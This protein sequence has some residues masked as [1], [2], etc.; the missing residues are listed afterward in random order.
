MLITMKSTNTEFL[1]LLQK[2]P[3]SF[4]GVQLRSIKNGTGIGFIVS[5]T[6]YHMIF[7]DTKYSF[8]DQETRSQ[9][10]FQSYCNPRVFLELASEFLRH[11]Y[12]SKSDWNNQIVPWLNKSY[13]ELDVSHIHVLEIENVYVDSLAA[14][15]EF[16]FQKYFP[17]VKLE[18]KQGR[19]YNL[20]ITTDTVHR[21]INLSALTCMYLSATNDQHWYLGKELVQKYIKIMK[22][23]E[24]VPYFIIYLFAKRCIKSKE[25]FELLKSELS[26]AFD[27][28]LNLVWGN[29]QEMRL[30]VA[31]E[32][33][34]VDGKI[35]YTV[36]EVGCGEMDYPYRYLGKL[37]QDKKWYA[38]DLTNYGHLVSSINKKFRSSSLSFDLLENIIPTSDMFLLMMEVIEHM[39]IEESKNFLIE[40]LNK[41]Q[42]KKALI[43][44]PNV[45]FNKYYGL[46]D[47]F[48]HPGH[49]FELTP[50]EFHVFMKEVLEKVSIPYSYKMIDIGDQVN[51]DY[52]SMGIELNYV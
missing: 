40:V 48:R 7:Q 29:T 46:A 38:T 50:T 44:T 33:M 36:L 14:G 45:N 21:L 22:N 4:E 13:Q 47:N 18:H 51:E 37:T 16:V 3:N 43:T 20:K 24:S 32:S 1:S 6:E 15:R 9:I 39:P 12:K 49:C 10:D 23:L 35:P 27:G 52:L 5:A 26:S 25:D 42:P 30:A 34:M 17:E 2:N 28:Y 31:G 8:I 11:G 41:Y 19:L